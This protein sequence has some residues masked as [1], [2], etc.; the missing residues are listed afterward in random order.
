MG[1]IRM[2]A[3]RIAAALVL[4][5]LLA[6]CGY[7]EQIS[8]PAGKIDSQITGKTEYE[9]PH[10]NTQKEQTS[11]PEKPKDNGEAD[12][13]V[14]EEKEASDSSRKSQHNDNSD[15]V[16]G[17]PAFVLGEYPSPDK[18]WV[19]KV[20]AWGE[21]QNIMARFLLVD[22]DDS[23]QIMEG[24]LWDNRRKNR[25]PA[26]IWLDAERAL[27]NG[28]T[29]WSIDGETKDLKPP[30]AR[31]IWDYAVNTEMSRL[32]LIGNNSQGMGVWV[33]DL[34]TYHL[35]EI[36]SYPANPSWTGGIDFRVAWDANDNLYFDVDHQG[37]PAIYRYD[38]KEDK[39]GLFLSLAANPLSTDNGRQITYLQTNGYYGN[40]TLSPLRK[41]VEVDAAGFTG[42]EVAVLAVAEQYFQNK[43]RPVGNEPG[44]IVLI[45]ENIFADRAVVAYGPW[46]SEYF[47]ELVLVRGEGGWQV[48]FE[49]L[50]H[51][52][53]YEEFGEVIHQLVAREG[54]QFG[55]EPGKHVIG[56]PHVT[57]STAVFLVGK[58]GYPW[59]ME[60]T[61]Q[62]NAAGKW[63]LLAT[64]NL[65]GSVQAGAGQEAPTV[66]VDQ[67]LNAIISGDYNL[68]YQL[69]A[70]RDQQAG[71]LPTLEQFTEWQKVQEEKAKILDFNSGEYRIGFQGVS[72]RAIV[73][74]W[75]TLE[76]VNGN[77]VYRYGWWECKLDNGNWKIVWPIEMGY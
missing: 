2:P 24:L 66:G 3:R 72:R 48:A 26:V 6:G 14:Q 62:S 53:P 13:V 8:P 7:R 56:M 54:Y 33:V 40:N 73:Q 60:Y 68:A 12:R 76:D 15:F 70:A 59:E 31:W 17:E 67:Y 64:R 11:G 47:G 5:L 29:L 77:E 74:V 37:K 9:E 69:I 41:S 28:T 4:F 43:G 58:Y 27:L 65:S 50:R 71:T 18:R 1:V 25:R 30:K 51:Y 57:D 45:V 55:E 20:V 21:A 34:D 10:E 42:G 22:G 46:A 49:K 23:T 16:L 44:K 38:W 75:L 63:E 61:W 35:V 52:F 36:Y 39:V 32:G 19:I